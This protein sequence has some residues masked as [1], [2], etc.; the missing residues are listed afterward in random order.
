MKG[1][2]KYNP[3]A[4]ACLTVIYGSCTY[5]ECCG[6]GHPHRSFWDIFVT[7]ASIT[8]EGAKKKARAEY[9]AGKEDF[10]EEVLQT[11]NLCDGFTSSPSQSA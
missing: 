2:N 7:E 8:K 1:E 4:F 3:Y 9:R 5:Q 6:V 11:P 10:L